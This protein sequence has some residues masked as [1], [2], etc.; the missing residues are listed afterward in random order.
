VSFVLL[1]KLMRA[2]R[3]RAPGIDLRLRSVD[4]GSVLQELRRGALDLAVGAIDGVP[5][6]AVEII[7]LFS[8]R[9][10]CVARRLHPAL[11]PGI[12]AKAFA[13]FPHVLV[14][15]RSDPHGFIDDALR[16]HGLE[17]RV[18]LTVP[19]FLA[20][21]FIV[22][23]TDMVAALAERVALRLAATARIGIAPLPVAVAPWTVGLV[24]L[25]A[26]PPD[27]AL[28]W[29]QELVREVAAEV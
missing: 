9:L 18:A 2:L 27:A 19:H 5:A 28:H 17:R 7:P 11:A 6:A 20:V 3:H 22:A 21:P 16:R 15:P 10:V 23:A 8:E 29:F 4:R 25:K 14:S 13:G 24:R 12:D 1:P 26:A